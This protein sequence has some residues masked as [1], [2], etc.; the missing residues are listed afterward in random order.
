MGNFKDWIRTLLEI[1][2]G[3]KFQVVTFGSG[4]ISRRIDVE[5]G[6]RQ[7]D[8]ILGYLFI[9]AIEISALSMKKS[10]AK[11]YRTNKGNGQLIDIYAD[12]LSIY[13]ESNK[14]NKIANEINV[15]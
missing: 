11:A 14:N 9:K 6:C 10:K 12:D 5:L 1:N 4:N 8:P 3:K 15:L 7:G 13:L 2:Q